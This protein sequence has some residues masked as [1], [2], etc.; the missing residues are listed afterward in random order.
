[1]D[2]HNNK[3]LV[4]KE[5][6]AYWS[7]VDQYVGGA[8]HA[9]RHLI[10]ARFWH[11]FLYDI[12]VVTTEEPFKRLQHVGLI[13]G[14][15]GKKMGK[16][17]GNTINSNDIV[18]EY[19]ADALRVYEMFMGQFNTATSWDTK[20]LIGFWRFLEKVWKL[21]SKVVEEVLDS[22]DL[23]VQI[24]KT[25]KKVSK[26]IESFKF[27]TGIAKLMELSNQMQRED[28]ISKDHYKI[29]LLL[30]H[31]FA[32]HITEELWSQCGES[33]SI[34]NAGW[35]KYEEEK[36]KTTKSTIGIL[37]N[38]KVRER[39]E[40]S[41]NESEEEVKK[42][43]LE[44]EKIQSRVDSNKELEILYIPGRIFNIITKTKKENE[45]G[46]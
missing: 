28:H 23:E 4:S 21:K 29:F 24:H 7:P 14:E 26:D 16:R 36:V 10:Y 44:L 18:E 40:V 38:G 9:T 6:E 11:K 33:Y 5:K 12:G 8:E 34:Y 39:I 25:I 19:G 17:F 3:E 32:P 35:P 2:P 20:S 27:N 41:S 22:P 43:V 13:M 42:R 1:M 31:P 30:L 15:D 46:E 37:I 45:I